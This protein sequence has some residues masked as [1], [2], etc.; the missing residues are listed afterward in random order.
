MTILELNGLTIESNEKVIVNNV[1]LQLE[2]GQWHSIIGESGSGKSVTA[3]A[4]GR[5]LPQSL[6]IKSGKILLEGRDMKD[7]CAEEMRCIRGHRISYIFQD[8]TSSFAPF[9]KIEKQ[10]ED[11]LKAHTKL[12]KRESKTLMLNTFQELNLPAES[13]LKKYPCQLSGGQ[14]QRA[15]IAFVMMLGPSII[16]ADEPTT[17]LDSISAMTVLSLLKKFQQECGCSI[18]FITHDL[19]HVKRYTNSISIIKNGEIIEQGYKS[20]I[21]DS[22]QH[23]YTKHLFSAIPSLYETRERLLLEER[24]KL[25]N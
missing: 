22:P 12:T 20:R 17:A 16:I 11:M 2:R 13:V 5:M 21:L 18:L 23:E 24:M 6:K 14:L 10:C 4:I 8:Y 15:A 25:V 3:A 1:H 19:R 9:L 7:F